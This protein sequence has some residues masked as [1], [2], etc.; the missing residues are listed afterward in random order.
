MKFKKLLALV[1]AVLTVLTLATVA[2]AADSYT[3]KF[4]QQYSGILEIRGITA[5][6]SIGMFPDLTDDAQRVFTGWFYNQNDG[7]KHYVDSSFVPTGDMT[8]IAEMKSSYTVRFIVPGS[9]SIYAE[10]RSRL[11]APLENSRRIPKR[12]ECV[13]IFGI[14]LTLA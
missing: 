11:E 8:I 1:L 7:E 5:G 6:D 2:M 14:F 13:L 12:R 4:A 10:K 9:T 3:I